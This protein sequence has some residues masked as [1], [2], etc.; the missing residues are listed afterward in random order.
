MTQGYF[1]AEAGPHT[2][3]DLVLE[4]IRRDVSTRLEA[5][6]V[7]DPVVARYLETD[8]VWVSLDVVVD[9][10]LT[11]TGPVVPGWAGPDAPFAGVV[12]PPAVAAMVEMVR[13]RIQAGQRFGREPVVFEIAVQPE[14]I[15]AG[16]FGEGE[17]A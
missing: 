6:M 10:E 9:R 5:A 11:P 4:A 1:G 3:A 2:P 8:D 7:A 15:P 14:A 16:G 13:R 12:G 17:V